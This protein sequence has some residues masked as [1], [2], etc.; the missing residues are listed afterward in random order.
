[1]NLLLL[2]W[3]WF[4]VSFF[5]RGVGR[6]GLFRSTPWIYRWERSRHSSV[7]L[8]QRPYHSL[9]RFIPRSWKIGRSIIP[10]RSGDTTVT[11]S[12]TPIIWRWGMVSLFYGKRDNYTI[13]SSGSLRSSHGN[14]SPFFRC[15]QYH[16]ALTVTSGVPSTL[17]VGVGWRYVGTGPHY[18]LTR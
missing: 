9:F 13:V 7:E 17:R 15:R 2:R 4:V 11:S 14:G 10:S 16:N 18:S 12:K 8:C 1:M 5:T 3:D 6:F